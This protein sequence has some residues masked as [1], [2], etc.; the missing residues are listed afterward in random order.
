[1]TKR[2]GEYRQCKYLVYRLGGR[3]LGSIV[4]QSGPNNPQ[5]LVNRVSGELAV[6]VYD[7]A[8]TVLAYLQDCKYNW[9]RQKVEHFGRELW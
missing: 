1:M 9:V 7:D 4:F 2:G 8:P 6:Q 5:W 3:Y